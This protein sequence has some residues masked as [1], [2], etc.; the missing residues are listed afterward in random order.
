MDR[1]F[2]CQV[3][4]VFFLTGP[5]TP[6]LFDRFRRGVVVAHLERAGWNEHELYRDT[7]AKV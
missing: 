2:I 1:I 3:L 7:L 5:P 4:L 6:D